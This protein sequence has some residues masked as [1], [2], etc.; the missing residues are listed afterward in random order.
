MGRLEKSNFDELI[1]SKTRLGIISALVGGDKLEFTYLRDALKLSDGNLS[2]QIRKLE[3]A[4][5]IKVDKVF[6]ERKPKTFCK[7]TAKGRKALRTL[8]KKLENL[9]NLD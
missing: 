8:I 1:L 3:E 2:V 9:V 7:I 6:V 4:G 5:Y